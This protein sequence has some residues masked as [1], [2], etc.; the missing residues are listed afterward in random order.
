LHII[1]SGWSTVK[2]KNHL[3]AYGLIG[4]LLATL[5][6]G[7]GLVGTQ[8][9]AQAL[10]QVLAATAAVHL[11]MDGDMMHD[12]IRADV[13]NAMLGMAR[14][15]ADRVAAATREL[16]EHSERFQKDFSA[17]AQGGLAAPVRAQ[18]DVVDPLLKR[19]VDDA[20][21]VVQP[22]AGS[23]PAAAGA[24]LAG[25]MKSF[26]TLEE[27]IQKLDDLIAAHAVD[28]AAAAAGAAMQSTYWIGLSLLVVLVASAL[29]ARVLAGRLTRPLDAAVQV[30]DRI[31]EGDLSRAV[32]R[33]DCLEI[34]QLLLALDHMQGKL[35]HLTASVRQRA[36]SVAVA[37]TQVHSTSDQLILNTQVHAAT[38]GDSTEAL[39][40]ISAEIQTNLRQTQQANQLAEGASR[41]AGRGGE[42][43]GQVVETMRGINSTSRRI[44][45]I[46]GVIDGIAF[47][48][49]ILALNAAVEA[50]R[51]GEQGRGFAVVASE[52]RSLAQRSANAAKEIKSLITASVEHVEHGTTLVDNAGATMQ[53]IVTAIG[54]V[55]ELMERLSRDSQAHAEG[56]DSVQR[57][58]TR[59]D[60]ATRENAGLV[61]DSARAAAS[62]H[63]DADE[64]VAAVASFKLHDPARA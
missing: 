60:S 41:V 36:V 31:A 38:M 16:A 35:S 8:R 53:E 57:T 61:E 43:V 6:A 50:A 3:L 56:I 1:I 46:I 21:Q 7:I 51:A 63:G 27:Q 40:R 24:A 42:V 29:A 18:F 25:F 20:R 44:H 52:V 39:Q 55:R 48:T 5:V 22:A 11:S 49:N 37:S 28:T 32:P 19:Y 10:D 64:L 4:A 34:N 62:L 2:L 59:L 14:A 13:L 45:D 26:T 58:V 12:A 15:D 23:D 54:Q 30:A 47:Q 33:S 9:Q 17:L